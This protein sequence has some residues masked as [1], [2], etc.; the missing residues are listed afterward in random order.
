MPSVSEQRGFQRLGREGA[1]LNW[2]SEAAERPSAWW[3]ALSGMLFGL[4]LPLL[5]V[6]V[7]P[8]TDYPNHL[9]R[10]MFLASGTADPVTSKI[11]AA[12]WQIAPNLALDVILPPLLAFISP[13]IAGKIVL[14]LAALLPATGA[15]ALHRA[16]FERRSY[17]VLAVGLAVYNVPFLLGFINFQLGVGVAFWGGA[18]WVW[19]ARRMLLASVFTG[20]AFG[21][22]AFF[23][24]LFAFALFALLIGC[25]ELAGV[26]RRGPSSEGIMRFACIR[27]GSV[28]AALIVPLALYLVSPL[29]STGGSVFR[30]EWVTKLKTLAVPVAGY[31]PGQTYITVATLA[32]VFGYLILSRRIQIAALAFLAFPILTIVFLALPTGAKG[33]FYIDTRIPVMMAFLLFASTLPKVSRQVGAGIFFVLAALFVGRIILINN[34]WMDGQQDVED[35]RAVLSA[36]TPG[37]RVL[38]VDAL[39]DDPKG[40][41][42]RH[43]S[44]LH[45]YPKSYW[46]YASFAYIDRK[47]F[48]ADAFTLYGQQPV[49]ARPYYD[50]SGNPGAYPMQNLQSLLRPDLRPS[51]KKPDYLTGWSSKFDY[52]LVMNAGGEKNLANALPERLRLVSRRGFAALFEVQHTTR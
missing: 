7:P 38:A 4:I 25:W 47:A 21:L 27:L 11:F 48:W 22:A 39:K 1:W 17:W 30:N 49:I 36:V 35:V 43:R 18:V 16:L 40:P 46:H 31:S 32:L 14:G 52:I 3:F 13:L 44:L 41:S 45:D 28:L 23:S 37:S 24:H 15:V 9:A 20:M 2:L 8:L 33:V 50:R 29:A 51:G 5:F 19:M 10:A 42:I 6:D 34:V 26:L 12:N